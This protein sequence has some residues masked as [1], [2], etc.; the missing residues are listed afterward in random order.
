MRSPAPG[1]REPWE[2]SGRMEKSGQAASGSDPCR[3]GS[4]S[5]ADIRPFCKSI[6]N[7]RRAVPPGKN[8]RL[9]CH[10]FMNGQGTVTMP[11]RRR[12][13]ANS[14]RI[15][16]KSNPTGVPSA[17]PFLCMKLGFRI[18]VYRAEGICH[19]EPVTDVTGVAISKSFRP[20]FVGF[21]LFTGGLPR[22]LT[23]LRNDTV[24]K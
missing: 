14:G 1:S 19:C 15:P 17:R 13:P 22:V 9:Q 24:Y 8:Y 10:L 7:G 16:R 12:R 23:H 11:L 6:P 3:P 4:R 21:S 20:V 2:K 18:L 5:A